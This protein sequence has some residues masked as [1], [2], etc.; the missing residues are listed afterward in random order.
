MLFGTYRINEHKEVKPRLGFTFSKGE[1]NFYT[2]SIQLIKDKLDEIYDWSADVMNKD[3]DPVKAKEK[4][5]AQPGMLVCDALMDQQI[6]SGV[7]NIIKNEVLFRI[8]VHPESKVGELPAVKMKALLK[9]AVLYSF[10]FLEWKKAFVLKKH[11]LAYNKAVCPRDGTPFTRKNM[12][13]SNRKTFFCRT[14]QQL[15]A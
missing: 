3:W 4:M 10:E 1:L 8:K 11:W 12:G 2:C 14:C 6:F 15:Y 9:E 13:R 7:G 5:L